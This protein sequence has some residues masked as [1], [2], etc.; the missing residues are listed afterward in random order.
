MR[1]RVV[2]VSKDHIARGVT[3]GFVQADHGKQGVVKGMSGGDSI[4]FS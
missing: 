2:G 4:S 1:Y 3:G